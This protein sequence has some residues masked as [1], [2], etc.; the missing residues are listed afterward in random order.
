MI[1]YGVNHTCYDPKKTKIVSAASCTTNCAAPIIQVMHN[2]FEV[3]EVMI[4]SVHALTSSQRTL[5]G[6]IERGKVIIIFSVTIP[7]HCLLFIITINLY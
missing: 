2:K 3:I 1:V 7:L 6:P 4:S 5:D